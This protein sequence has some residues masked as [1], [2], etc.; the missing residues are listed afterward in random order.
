M[1]HMERRQYGEYVDEQTRLIHDDFLEQ[2][3]DRSR[4]MMACGWF[5][6]CGFILLLILNIINITGIIIGVTSDSSSE[7][8]QNK[9]TISLANYLI[10]NSSVCL[11][12]CVLFVIIVLLIIFGMINDNKYA[13]LSSVP[14]VIMLLT[15]ALYC[16]IMTII[17]IIELSYQFPSCK[18]EQPGASAMTIVV[19][20][21]NLMYLSSTCTIKCKC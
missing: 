13:L 18:V 3:N 11:A 15:F 21:M 19:V 7:C 1:D 5:M 10:V 16:L 6:C 20:I 17:G 2:Q 8:Y 14:A 4:N 9:Y 12:F